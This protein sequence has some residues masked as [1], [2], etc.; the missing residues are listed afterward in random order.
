MM[1]G[2]ESDT[3]VVVDEEV[4]SVGFKPYSGGSEPDT[5]VVVDEEVVSVGFKPYSG[6]VT[7]GEDGG[8]NDSTGGKIPLGLEVGDAAGLL[9]EVGYEGPPVRPGS[10]VSSSGG[11]DVELEEVGIERSGEEEVGGDAEGSNSEGVTTV[12][13]SIVEVVISSSLMGG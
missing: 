5:D 11:V 10:S 6:G 8:D 4:V 2:S 1:G 9:L 7:P 3:D 13:I 12:V